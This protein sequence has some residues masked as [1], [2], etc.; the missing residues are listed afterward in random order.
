MEKH[1]EH[2]M[3]S[4]MEKLVKMEWGISDPRYQT[5]VL[6]FGESTD[7]RKV[8]LFLPTEACE[9]WLKNVGSKYGLM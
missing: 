2:D 4:C 6:L 3:T 1:K 9:M 7:L 8:W 5:T